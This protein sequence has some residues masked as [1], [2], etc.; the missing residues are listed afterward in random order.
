[1]AEETL[2]EKF[3]KPLSSFTTIL[4]LTPDEALVVARNDGWFEIN[5]N[6]DAVVRS[7]NY[8]V[9]Q[10]NEITKILKKN[11][12]NDSTYMVVDKTLN[13]AENLYKTPKDITGD[14]LAAVLFS[15][16]GNKGPFEQFKN[17]YGVNGVADTNE[18]KMFLAHLAWFH[19]NGGITGAFVGTG[20]E[21]NIINCFN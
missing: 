3:S 18:K 19:G 11:D 7:V 9:N 12:R 6:N 5:K 13:S 20:G 1:M 16:N 10:N 17:F 14:L 2:Y 21:C 8:T 4:S 15:V